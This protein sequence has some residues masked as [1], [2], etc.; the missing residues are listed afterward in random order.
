MATPYTTVRYV[1]H[2]EDG[3]FRFRGGETLA[4]GRFDYEG[5]KA[6]IAQAPNLPPTPLPDQYYL[7]VPPTSCTR[8]RS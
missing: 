8:T 2:V 3:T 5:L 4:N 6:A 1:D 7:V